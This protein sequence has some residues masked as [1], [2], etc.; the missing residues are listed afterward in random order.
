[1]PIKEEEE[2]DVA[3]I[4]FILF[5]PRP[6]LDVQY[7]RVERQQQGILPFDTHICCCMLN[8]HS[9]C[10]LMVLFCTALLLLVITCV[11]AGGKFQAA[12]TEGHMFR[13]GR[14]FLAFF[15]E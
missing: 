4:V 13:R 6:H 7:D 15:T 12:V 11:S 8:K 5:A 1:M 14:V 2:L 9:A 10:I 3:R